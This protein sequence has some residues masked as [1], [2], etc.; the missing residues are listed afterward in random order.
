MSA[1]SKYYASYNR[2]RIRDDTAAAAAALALHHGLSNKRH[3]GDSRTATRR[4]T[5]IIALPPQILMPLC[6]PSPISHHHHHVSSSHLSSSVL[7]ASATVSQR[8]SMLTFMNCLC[9]R[10]LNFMFIFMN[11]HAL[12]KSFSDNG[13][14]I[15]LQRRK[16]KLR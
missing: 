1:S 16:L 6:L 12:R 11:P 9:C 2:A 3:V 14:R 10:I 4:A 13:K 15:L 8:H 7:Q 5:D